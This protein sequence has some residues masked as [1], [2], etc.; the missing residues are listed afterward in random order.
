MPQRERG[1]MLL[2][3]LRRRV[4]RGCKQNSN[5]ATEARRYAPERTTK[6]G[7]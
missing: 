6:E 2:S 7:A 5:H 3:A 1:T 4:L